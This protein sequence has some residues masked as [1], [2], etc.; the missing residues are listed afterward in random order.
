[1]GTH[2]FQPGSLNV[3]LRDGGLL[4]LVHDWTKQA[5]TSVSAS[6]SVTTTGH[7][8][9]PPRHEYLGFSR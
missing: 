1:V 5:K 2:R 4:Y 8:Q 7:G 9:G 6:R 3:I